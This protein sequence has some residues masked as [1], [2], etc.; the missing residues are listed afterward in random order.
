MAQCQK[1]HKAKY[2]VHKAGEP[3]ESAKQAE[4][5][6]THYE[7]NSKAFHHNKSTKDQPK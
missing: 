4:I 2:A 3:L 7:F 5:H 1:R 6:S